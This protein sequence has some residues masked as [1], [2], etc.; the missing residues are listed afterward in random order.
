MKVTKL[1]EQMS[2]TKTVKVRGRPKGSKN[3]VKEQE[4]PEM[5]KRTLDEI[6][7]SSPEEVQKVHK[8]GRPPKI[9]KEKEIQVIAPR[10]L[11]SADVCNIIRSCHFGNVQSLTFQ[12]LKVDFQQQLNKNV[13]LDKNKSTKLFD[14]IPED[15]EISPIERSSV[16]EEQFDKNYSQMMIDDPVAWEKT[17]IDEQQT[18]ESQ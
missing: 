1:P 18:G 9:L 4:V 11:T 2:F 8:L 10:E 3:K 14:S 13:S 6:K 12:N 15:V 16:A 5:M 7:K 17:Y